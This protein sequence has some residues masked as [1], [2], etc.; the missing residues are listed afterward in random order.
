MRGQ[1]GF[2]VETHAERLAGKGC[3]Q[4]AE[5]GRRLAGVETVAID[6]REP[7]APAAGRGAALDFTQ[8]CLQGGAEA[9]VP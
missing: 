1:A 6:Q 4:R 3:L 9:V 2:A 7:V 8:A 5:I